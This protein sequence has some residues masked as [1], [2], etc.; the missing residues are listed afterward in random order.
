MHAKSGVGPDIPVVTDHYECDLSRVQTA[1]YADL[2]ANSM[3]VIYWECDCANL[4][5]NLPNPVRRF[6]AQSIG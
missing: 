3:D 1:L 2:G 4:H 5:S 6:T